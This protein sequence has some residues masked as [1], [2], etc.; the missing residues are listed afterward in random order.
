MKHILIVTILLVFSTINNFSQLNEGNSLLGPSVGLWTNLSVPTYGANYEN[1]L[2]Q[3][4]NT[5]TIS[6][7]GILRYTT[8]NDTWKY[9]SY[10]EKI[11]YTYTVIGLQ[12]N[13]HFNKIGN[14]KFVPFLG[15]MLG[16]NIVS[17]S[18]SNNVGSEFSATA[19]SG[20]WIWGQAG[21]RYFLGKNIAGTV[22]ISAGNYN[23]I[24]GEVGLD[25]KF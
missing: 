6:I 10:N 9:G 5:S 23:F 17:V 2:K 1:Q 14:K 12:S 19:N 15:V 22:R 24:A 11:D 21:A 4:G 8:Y 7:G 16:Y 3:V 18:Y 25:F 20:L 13:L